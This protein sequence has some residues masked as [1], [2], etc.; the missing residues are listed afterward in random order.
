M[1]D[2]LTACGTVLDDATTGGDVAGQV[3]HSVAPTLMLHGMVHAVAVGSSGAVPVGAH[4]LH[5]LHWPIVAL[6][7]CALQT[8]NA[9]S[10]QN[11]KSMRTIRHAG[12][13]IRAACQSHVL[14]G[15]KQG[16]H[17][18]HV[19]LKHAGTHAMTRPHSLLS[20]A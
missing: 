18:S 4:L 11:P 16:A 7:W 5:A 10:L 12:I 8:K 6:I 1:W 9:R 17:P 19:P 3:A 2:A 14:Y 13:S 15:G 20:I